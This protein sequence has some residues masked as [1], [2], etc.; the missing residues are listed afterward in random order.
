MAIRKREAWIARHYGDGTQFNGDDPPSP[1]ISSI[2]GI[3][4]QIKWLA[5]GGL[6]ESRM[7]EIIN[8]VKKK[9]TKEK[10]RRDL[11]SMWIKTYHEKAEKDIRLAS[12]AYLRGA[13][14]RYSE[15]AEKNVTPSK[16]KG[17]IDFA[18]LFE[19][20]QEVNL[21][22]QIIGSKWRKWFFVTGRDALRSIL[23]TAGVPFEEISLN[24]KL[25][26]EYINTMARTIVRT[27][28]TAITSIIDNGLM[29]GLAIEEIAKNIQGATAFDMSRSRMIARTESTRAANSGTLQAYQDA[30]TYGIKMQK[31]WLSARDDV[32]RDTHER[33][34]GQRVGVNEMFVSNDGYEAEY[35]GNFGEPSEDINC[36]CTIIPIIE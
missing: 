25:A 30:Q 15:R 27:Q 24:D 34:D 20:A 5:V 4:A 6:G 8:E 26:S 16:I 1:N 3:I 18:S 21:V 33:L 17:V 2:A 14:K 7:K 22:A 19:T 35:P 23:Q 12:S 29:E 31:E 28:E 32:V 13:A 36:R 11:W 10:A 9:Q